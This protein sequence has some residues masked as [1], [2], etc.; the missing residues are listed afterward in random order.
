MIPPKPIPATLEAPPVNGDG[1]ADG[2]TGA[3]DGAE[4]AAGLAAGA[5]TAGG[6]EETRGAVGVMV[7]VTWVTEVDWKGPLVAVMVS[8]ELAVTVTVEDGPG[9]TV[10]VSA[11]TVMTWL[12]TLTV[13]TLMLVT[14][15]GTPGVMTVS[16]TVVVVAGTVTVSPEVAVMVVSGAVM[17]VA[18]G[19][20]VV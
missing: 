6:P 3:P 14:T 19:Q 15:A 9:M 4:G 17:V 13:S 7:S 5:L 1:A 10:V 8:P 11:V 16:T 12:G 18:L 20:T 2:A